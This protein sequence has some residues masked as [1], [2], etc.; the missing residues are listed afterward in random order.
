MQEK[1]NSCK[2]KQILARK[3]KFVQEEANSSKKKQIVRCNKKQNS[4]RWKSS[5][6]TRHIPTHHNTHY[7]PSFP[8][9]SVVLCMQVGYLGCG[10]TPFWHRQSMG[11]PCDH[12]GGMAYEMKEDFFFALFQITVLGQ[13]PTPPLI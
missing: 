6:F 2:K 7:T 4:L 10:A 9:P 12:M 8:S 1:A 3:S 13:T 5:F 11:D